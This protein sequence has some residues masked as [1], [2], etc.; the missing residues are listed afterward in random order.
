MS[1]KKKA[2]F[3]DMDGTTLDDN[4][5][6]SKEN[7]DAL[8]KTIEAGHEVVVTTGR[9]TPSAKYLLETYGLDKINCRY[10]ISFNGGEMY[11]YKTDEVLYS[12]IIPPET[13]GALNQKAK[14]LG[15]YIQAYDKYKVLTEI[16]DERLANYIGKTQ[17]EYEIVA[18]L[19]KATMGKTC[20]MLAID[21]YH[22]E[23]LEQFAK[24][25]EVLFG[26]KIDVYF[27]SR[28]YLEIMP[29]GVSK[30][31]AL[32]S[33]CEK[34]GV[35]IENTIA[36]GDEHNDISM[37]SKAG[38]GCAVANA[39]EETKLAANYVTERDNNHSAIAEVVEKFIFN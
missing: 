12:K 25:I 24:E 2:I 33:F 6:I 16:E 14:E 3:L 18:D 11:D 19:E 31:N 17:M 30:G 4:R 37:I 1:N 13:I 26:D 32:C 27:S 35:F 22:R 7:L 28:E 15:I 10:L 21:L 36:V 5:E 20:K 23:V 39:I 34:T 9:A 29:K 38:V 8:K